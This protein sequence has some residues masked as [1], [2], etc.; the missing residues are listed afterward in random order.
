MAG[1]RVITDGLAFPEGPVAMPDG[2]VVLV[3]IGA[4]A[5]T[6]VFPDG[7]KQTMARPGD[8]PNGMAI[9]PNGKAYVCNNG[10]FEF[11]D[12]EHGSRPARQSWN[13]V[14]GRIERIDLESGEVEVLY[15]GTHQVPLRGPN[16]IVFDAH[17]GFYFTDL[18]KVRERDMD[19]GAV[20]YAKADGSAIEEIAFPIVMPNGVGLS[21]D[22]NTLYVAETEGARLWAFP[23]LSPGVVD[24][25]PWPSPHGGRMLAASPGGQ[26][27]RFDSLALE[28]NGN[29]CV[30][31]LAHGGI[32]VIAP[33]GTLVEHVP[34]P[35]FHTTNICFGGPDLRTAYI[36]LSG[37]GRLVS[38]EWPRAGLPLNYLNVT[39]AG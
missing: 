18:G 2:S 9:G 13:Y 16:D 28:A 3:E 15:R 4:G 10:G 31:T 37:S 34:M 35:D 32:S 25:Q 17:G 14:G 6:R 36:T 26:Y 27:M 8:G 21:P 12:T 23:V 30:A 11:I 24:K 29:I 5:I 38:M 19:R 39:P 1:M 33:D 22:G 7:S 20:F